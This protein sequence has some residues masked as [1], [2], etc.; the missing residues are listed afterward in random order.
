MFLKIPAPREPAGT[1]IHDFADIYCSTGTG[2]FLLK[3]NEL[4]RVI[5][6]PT[7]KISA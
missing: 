5:N 1:G 2:F 4:I 7:G 6:I 3:I